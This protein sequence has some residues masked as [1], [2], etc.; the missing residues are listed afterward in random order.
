MLKAEDV[1]AVDL[2]GSTITSLTCS[3]AGIS[4]RKVWPFGGNTQRLSRDRC[5]LLVPYKLLPPPPSVGGANL[6]GKRLRAGSRREALIR[7][8]PEWVLRT[9][10]L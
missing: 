7:H 8:S 1:D 10:N 6:P 4:W 9:I 5:R 2:T 3:T